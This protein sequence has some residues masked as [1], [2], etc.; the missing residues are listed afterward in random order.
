[1]ASPA[2]AAVAAPSAGSARS[3][4]A[5]GSFAPLTPARL[6]D[7]RT[8]LGAG[9]PVAAYGTIHLSV[10]GRGGV[11]T[12]GVSAVAVNVTVTGPKK[13]G[14]VTVYPDGAGKPTASNLNFTAG[15]TIPNLVI[16][17]V[18]ANGKIALANN[19]GGTIQLIADVA[20]F[21]LGG[22]PSVPGAYVPLVPARVL[23]TRVNTGSSGP[24]RPYD[25]IHLSI[26]GVGGVPTTGVGALVLNVTVTAPRAAGNLTVYPNGAST[27]TTSNLNFVA[28][29]TIPNLVVVKVGMNGP[30]GSIAVTNNRGGLV[31]VIADVAGYYVA[32]TSIE[33]GAPTD[34][35]AY[36]TLTPSRVLD[37]R[38]GLG[39]SNLVAPHGTVHLRVA[40]RGGVP[41]IGTGAVV[42]NVTVT[43]PKSAGNITVYPDQTPMPT[44]SNLNFT[45]GQTIPNLVVAKV[46]AN[47]DVALTNNSGSTVQLIADV[48]GYHLA[49]LGEVAQIGAGSAHTCALLN[50][51]G[52][53][54]WGANNDGELGNGTTTDSLV[55]VAVTGLDSGVTSISASGD[56]TC[57]LTSNGAVYCWGM[58][59]YGQLG[60]G[61]SV[62]SSVPVPV[63]GL[64]EGV[65]SISAGSSYTCAV[66]ANG[67]GVCWGR[68]GDGQ[69]GNG[70]T[71]DASAP[72]AV[73]GLGSGVASISGGVNHTCAVSTTGSASCWGY[74]ASGALGNGTLDSSASPVPVTGLSSA[75]ASISA[76]GYQ[77]T[78][79]VLTSGAATCWGRNWRG[80]LG[81]GTNTDSTTPVTV[82]GLGSGVVSIS[83]GYQFTCATLTGG[84]ATCWGYNTDGELGNMSNG[85]SDVP[86]PV[87]GLDS[88]VVSL[89]AG[90][91]HSCSVLTNGTAR[92]WG[93]NSSGQLGDSTTTTALWPMP[94]TS[95]N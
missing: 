43:G 75:V 10:L 16:A 48:A 70:T 40:G 65:A 1:V 37:T 34:T 28:G 33:P 47:G 76:T 56:H 87:A 25:T 30:D 61:T 52:V 17:K 86:V 50:S 91:Q 77:H 83:S 15:Q 64:G 21:Y 82:T 69:L 11:P 92:C 31:D 13:A 39:G 88:G 55:P 29:Q 42:L 9:G 72:V 26:P 19:S 8:A 51:G 78:C 68:N 45:P 27:P 62:D 53:I 4:S 94:V 89:S 5:P 79:A 60:D 73:S 38:S 35:G 36:V 32:G 63:A 57:A 18:G 44:A 20:G 80:Q 74:N 46:G 6:L 12:A 90:W 81:D 54:C 49:S 3:A 22:V 66:L 67:A 24:V 95:L 71:T 23:D 85:E 93:F 41:A 84:S 7:T 2:P 59:A 58:N 14:N